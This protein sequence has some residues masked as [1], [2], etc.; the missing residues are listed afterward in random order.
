VLA[1]PGADPSDLS[2]YALEL[3]DLLSR[4]TGRV[5]VD[6][7]TE[8]DRTLD[9]AAGLLDR[10][11]N[12]RPAFHVTRLLSSVVQVDAGAVVELSVDG[13]RA[14][15]RSTRFQA[16]VQASGPAAGGG[17]LV[18]LAT[19]LT[20]GPDDAPT[21]QPSMRILEPGRCHE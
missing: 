12:P 5:W 17:V 9:T 1:A 13:Q 8:L 6:G 14:H 15:V 2:A 20:V 3:L 11:C 19:G 10:A 7:L 18:N 16:V 21:N 4:S